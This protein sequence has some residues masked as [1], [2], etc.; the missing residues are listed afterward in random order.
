MRNLICLA[1][2]VV[3]LAVPVVADTFGTGANQFMID[4]VNI[5]KATNPAS[6]IPTGNNFTFTGV[7]RDYRMG[8]YE[9]TNAQFAKFASNGNV[10]WTGADVPSNRVS[11]F[12]AAQFVN[13]LNTS[14]GNTAAY[15]F[16]GSTFAVWDVT[17][18]GY[19]VSNPFRNSK[20]KYFLPT[21][22]EWVKAAYW[23]GSAIQKYATKAGES[24]YQGNGSNGGWNYYDNGWATNPYGPWNVGSGSQELNGTFDMMG[25]VWEWMESPYYAGDYTS[26]SYRGVRGGSCYDGDYDLRSSYRDYDIPRDEYGILG[27]RVASIPEPASLLLLGLGGLLIRK[28]K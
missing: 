15:K 24:L 25:N 22:N 20:A 11:W 23:N 2:A 28:R 12:E 8:T 14:T 16:N 21:E 4:F 19:N 6:G 10:L 18:T 5:S 7:T 13:Y 1:A 26:G 9:I 27:F 3:M 17:D